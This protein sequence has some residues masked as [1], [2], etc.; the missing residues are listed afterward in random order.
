M[1]E[2]VAALTGL[3]TAVATALIVWVRG[4][5]VD[6][7]ARQRLEGALG[8]A[9]GLVMADSAVQAAG[10]QALDA[11]LGMAEDYVREAI[12]DTLKRL[13]VPDERL[14]KMVRGEVGKRLAVRL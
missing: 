11:A 5:V 13:G 8:R 1:D 3:A 10:A 6:W 12:P 9:A 2:L 14:A 4:Q 7:M